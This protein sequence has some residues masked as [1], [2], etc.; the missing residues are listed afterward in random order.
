MRSSGKQ[1][2][3]EVNYKTLSWH[4]VETLLYV[5]IGSR[6]P[7]IKGKIVFLIHL[8]LM[9]K[10]TSENKQNW[11]ANWLKNCIIFCLLSFH[12]EREKNKNLLFFCSNNCFILHDT[13][14]IFRVFPQIL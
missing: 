10:Q 8:Y 7:Q 1:G 11:N 4:R 3:N 13:N 5:E 14:R 12:P 9:I 2:H 6:N